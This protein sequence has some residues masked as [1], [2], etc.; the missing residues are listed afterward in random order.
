MTT[1]VKNAALESVATET[2]RLSKDKDG[3]TVA[4][5]TP[6]ILELVKRATLLADRE[7]KAKAEREEVRD[8]I[9][10]IMEEWGADKVE[11]DGK[12]RVSVAHTETT[13]VSSTQLREEYPA[14]YEAVAVT[15]PGTRVTIR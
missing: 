8:Q 12:T 3:K 10:A 6:K 4:E 2:V 1:N 15:T 5:A 14:V 7:K 13:R 11:H 9:T